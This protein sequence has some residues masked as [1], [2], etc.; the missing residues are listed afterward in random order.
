[1]YIMYPP[2]AAIDN[3]ALMAAVTTALNAALGPALATTMISGAPAGLNTLAEIANELHATRQRVAVIDA[4]NNNRADRVDALETT[5]PIIGAPPTLDTI[6]KI[7][8]V[9]QSSIA[10]MMRKSVYDVNNDAVVDNVDA[11]VF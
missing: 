10:D 6:G 11:G 3:A 4:D 2:P 8:A 9:L 5:T 7:T 1:M